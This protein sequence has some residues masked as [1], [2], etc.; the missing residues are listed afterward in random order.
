MLAVGHQALAVGLE[1]IKGSGSG[2]LKGVA[3]TLERVG[4][5]GGDFRDENYVLGGGVEG[6]VITTAR[7]AEV[8][9]RPCH[10]EVVGEAREV[11]ASRPWGCP[12]EPEPFHV[13]WALV[14]M[15]MTRG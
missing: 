8:N 12:K 15:G 4:E 9:R 2:G 7:D 3:T 13:L 14:Y 1:A 11:V 5:G 6:A 10:N